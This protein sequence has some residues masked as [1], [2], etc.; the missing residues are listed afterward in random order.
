M[1][2]TTLDN[3]EKYGMLTNSSITIRWS[4]IVGRSPK[5]NVHTDENPTKKTFSRDA[6]KEDENA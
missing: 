5:E 3:L 4:D 2:T 1:T 6:T